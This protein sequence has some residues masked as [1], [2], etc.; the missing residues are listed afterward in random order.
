M[1][2][3]TLMAS[4]ALTVA[5][6]ASSST[7]DY[8]MS[9][10]YHP[11]A[12]RAYKPTEPMWRGDPPCGRFPTSGSGTL[13]LTG[14]ITEPKL[15]HKQKSDYSHLTPKTRPFS[16]FFAEFTISMEGR[17]TEVRVLRSVSEEF[18][19]L[20]LRELETSVYRPATLEGVPVPVCATILARPHP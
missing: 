16:P 13:R 1:I 20:V 11:D 15:K 14:A 19:R 8:R 7:P 5:P 18:D 10:T 9:V 2:G 6:A 17:V 12:R 4:V 3:W